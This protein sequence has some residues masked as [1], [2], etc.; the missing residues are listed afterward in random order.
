MNEAGE[1]A[2]SSGAP[3]SPEGTTEP[4]AASIAD[5]SARVSA[6]NTQPL[7]GIGGADM[8]LPTVSSKLAAETAARLLQFRRA[9]TAGTE[10]SNSGDSS[11]PTFDDSVLTF[12]VC[13]VAPVF[14]WRDKT[15]T[16][17]ALK[18]KSKSIFSEL[19]G[20]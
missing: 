3:H 13:V 6:S 1:G 2:S 18:G 10:P 17:R 19:V 8:Q 12:E 7:I 14:Q 15:L 20:S 9:G 5:D 4:V 16:C 11:A